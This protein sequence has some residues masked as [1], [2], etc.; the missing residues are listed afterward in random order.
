MLQEVYVVGGH[1][2]RNT[3]D[4]GNVFSVPS[5][6]YAEFNMFLDPLAAKTVFESEVNITL[7]PLSTQRKVSSFATVIR[8]LRGTRKTAEV[9][10]SKRLL[11]SLHRLKQIHNRYHHMD[12]FLG[13]VLGAVVM[14]DKVSSLKPK[15]EKKPIKVLASGDESTDGKMVVDEK[16]GKLVKILS[17]VDENAY[18]NLYANKL[19]DQYQ[20]A[21][22]G[23]F[24]EQTRKWRYPHD[25]KP[26]QEK[27][28]QF[29]GYKA[30]YQQCE[31]IFSSNNN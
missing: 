4:K 19:G 22:V 24:K 13:E 26:S 5:N 30:F 7:I 14:A 9:A 15:F 17:N 6:Q 27:C 29:H 12:T 23:S 2:S 28:A 10:F 3:E 25:D 11:S 8:R 18:Y 21:K 31:Y 16:H 20:S 1:I